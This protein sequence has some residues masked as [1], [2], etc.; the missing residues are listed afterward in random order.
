MNFDLQGH[1]EIQR[2]L[3]EYIGD[4]NIQRS[5]ELDLVSFLHAIFGGISKKIAHFFLMSY[6][7]Q[8]IMP[9]LPSESMEIKR[10][11]P[12]KSQEWNQE[13]LL[14]LNKKKE[15]VLDK[16][17]E[18][19]KSFIEPWLEKRFGIASSQNYSDIWKI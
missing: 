12:G 1:R 14:L 18:I 11:P 15:Y 7:L 5:N 3:N 4:R 2:K 8:D 19:T 17:K 16:M 9:L 6:D 13:I 10:L